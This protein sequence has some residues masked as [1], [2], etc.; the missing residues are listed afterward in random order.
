MALSRQSRVLGAGI[1]SRF[2]CTHGMQELHVS[3]LSGRKNSGWLEVHAFPIDTY[4]LAP[5]TLNDDH[6]TIAPSAA[7]I[8]VEFDWEKLES[9]NALNI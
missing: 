1:R 7:G 4:T 9:D 2:L 8:G 5:L 3:L 6:M